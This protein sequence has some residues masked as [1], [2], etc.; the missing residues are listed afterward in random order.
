M[1]AVRTTGPLARALSPRRFTCCGTPSGFVSGLIDHDQRSRRASPRARRR[2]RV[3]LRR[4]PRDRTTLRVGPRP[5]A[6]SRVCPARAS[7]RATIVYDAR[8][9]GTRRRRPALDH[10]AA[11]RDLD[12]GAHRPCDARGRRRPALL[13][14][15][16]R[17]ARRAAAGHAVRDDGIAAA[18]RTRHAR[19]A[20]VR[21]Q[22][23]PRSARAPV[24]RRTERA[25]ADAA[26][27]AAAARPALAEAVRAAAARAALRVAAR[28]ARARRRVER[29][30]SGAPVSQRDR[31]ERGRVAPATAA[32]DVARAARERHAR[33][34]GRAS[35]RLSQ[36]DHLCGHLQARVRRHA[37]PVPRGRGSGGGQRGTV[38]NACS[39]ACT[40]RSTSSR[41][42]TSGGAIASRLPSER[43]STP[44]SR[45][46]SASAAA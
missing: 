46:A 8:R 11:A 31:H 23:R 40:I 30:P 17:R 43:I 1:A 5:R 15:S 4:D 35:G 21:L 33:H 26:H 14:L 42:I 10:P 6:C 41:P 19:V 37:E 24:R 34:A 3:R 27:A 45:A 9:I 7:G 39:T 20:S 38:S 25:R 2:A 16:R 36:P 32:V 12:S 28:H 22:R 18:A 44:A 13:A 29:A